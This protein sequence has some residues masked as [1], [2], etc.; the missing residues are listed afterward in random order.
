MKQ[1][2][3]GGSAFPELPT[4]NTPDGCI[5][6]NTKPGMSLRAYF[7]GHALSGWLASQPK[8]NGVPIRAI[9]ED[10]ES[11]ANAAILYADAL[12]AELGK[13]QA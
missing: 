8:N 1:I 5:S 2:N 9:Y 11:I 7:A 13:E 10:A 3:D 6:V 12:I 4:Y